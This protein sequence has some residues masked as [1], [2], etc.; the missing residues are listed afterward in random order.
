MYMISMYFQHFR[1]SILKLFAAVPVAPF[2]EAGVDIV[3]SLHLAD[4][5]VVSC[6]ALLVSLG[7]AIKR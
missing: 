7:F 6:F 5:T 1:A 4:G 3:A 2:D